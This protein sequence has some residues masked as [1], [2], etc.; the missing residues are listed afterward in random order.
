MPM[1]GH[2]QLLVLQGDGLTARGQ[3]VVLAPG[4]VSS[5]VSDAAGHDSSAGN[6]NSNSSSYA[7]PSSWLPGLWDAWAPAG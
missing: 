6:T 4:D 1:A 3:V 7:V 5:S 2:H